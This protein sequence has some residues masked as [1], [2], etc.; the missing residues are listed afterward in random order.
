MLTAKLCNESVPR[1]E[2]DD[3]IGERY[4]AEHEIHTLSASR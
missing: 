2:L 4:C 3:G 1:I